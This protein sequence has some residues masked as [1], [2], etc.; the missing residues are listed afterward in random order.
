MRDKAY[1]NA[2]LVL[3]IIIVI[4]STILFITKKSGY[5]TL[6]VDGTKSIDEN[7]LAVEKIFGL[8]K[9]DNGGGKLDKRTYLNDITV[10]FYLTP[11]SPQL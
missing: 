11:V 6:V 2:T 4:S 9:R 5:H 1:K 3:A 8:W 7:Y 10:Q